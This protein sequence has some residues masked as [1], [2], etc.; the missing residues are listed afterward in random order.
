MSVRRCID[1]ID[2]P[3]DEHCV[4]RNMYR[5]EIINTQKNCVILGINKNYTEMHGQQNIKNYYFLFYP[6][7]LSSPKIAHKTPWP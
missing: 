3:D 1:T 2:S 6:L 7:Q 4:T 5:S